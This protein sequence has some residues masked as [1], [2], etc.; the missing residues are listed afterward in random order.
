M[1]HHT[2]LADSRTASEGGGEGL[3]RRK[4]HPATGLN[5]EVVY[6]RLTL[7]VWIFLILPVCVGYSLPGT[8][9]HMEL[10]K[11]IYIYIYLKASNI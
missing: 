11:C 5:M 6:H 3:W 8:V 2:C 1:L 9:T 10:C 4:P 7:S